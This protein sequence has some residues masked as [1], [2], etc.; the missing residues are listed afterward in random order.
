MKN[1]NQTL[2]VKRDQSISLPASSQERRLAIRYLDW[3]RCKRKL[4]KIR[5][6]VPKL[7]L[8]YSFLFGITATSGFSL[9]TFSTQTETKLPTWGYPLYSLIFVFSLVTAIVFVYVD[10]RIGFDKQSEIDDIIED[11]KSI[12]ETFPNPVQ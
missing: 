8:V 11:M 12:E 9:L 5:Q 1:E 6:R 10:R 7:H 4:K 2:S 3:D